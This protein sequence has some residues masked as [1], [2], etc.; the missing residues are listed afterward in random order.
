MD[1]DV[2]IKV[3]NVSKKFSKSLKNS[4][5]Y[6]VKDIVK[7]MLRL[8]SHSE[9]LRPN[10]F[11]AVNDV[12][13][14]VKRGEALGLIG[15]NGSGK[16][17]LL[18]MLNGIFWPDK[19]K[20]A[21]RGRVGAL[22]AVGAG[23]HPMFTGRENIY[24]NGAIL[25][26]NKREIN[27]KLDAIVDFA[28]IGDFLDTPVKN[29]SSGMFVRLGFAI[30][31]HCNPSILLV[32]EILAVGDKDFQIKCYQ[33]MHE[34]KKGGTTIILVSHNEY[35]IRE[36]TKKCLYLD[37]GKKIFLGESDEAIS[38]YLKDTLEEKSRKF[39]LGEVKRYPLSKKAEIISLK[40]FDR[41]WNEVTYIES[42]SELNIV[43][44]CIM[45]EEL[46]NTIF[47]V[48][49]YDNNGFMYCANSGYENVSFEELSIGKVRIK[50]N[51]PH[52]HLPTNNY[53]CSAILAEENETN[54]I[55][56]HN[57]VYRFVVGRAMNARGSIK[58]LTKWEV[59]RV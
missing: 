2:V 35:T 19:G 54:L 5:F 51:I 50:I 46:N 44:E 29:Y 8:S 49:F 18:K 12:S 26:M 3:E 15:H 27:K 40:F 37:H 24:I 14:E 28:D 59:E 21:I 38:L 7:N 36:E 20:I 41:D 47:G 58:L 23:F 13:F 53:L 6:G 33:K 32:D 39:T 1:S 25:G 10:E 55:D 30:S 48:N 31:V 34:I 4:M 9:K 56:W 22:I 11:W 57:M 42:G 52:F 45:R 16:T 43:L 17:T